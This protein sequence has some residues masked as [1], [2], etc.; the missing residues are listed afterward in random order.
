MI[1]FIRLLCSLTRALIVHLL[2]TEVITWIIVKSTTN[3]LKIYK[4]LKLKYYLLIQN[5][6]RSVSGCMVWYYLLSAVLHW[7]SVSSAVALTLRSSVFSS[8]EQ[9]TD[10]F[11]TFWLDNLTLH[12]VHISDELET[13]SSNSHYD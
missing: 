6:K 2:P 13:I 4:F 12:R 10:L 5:S 3:T 11:F 7:N 8:L 9:D 1:C